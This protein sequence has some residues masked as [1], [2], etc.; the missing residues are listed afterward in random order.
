MEV[1]GTGLVLPALGNPNLPDLTSATLILTEPTL[2]DVLI[3]LEDLVLAAGLVLVALA[4]DDA[5]LVLLDLTSTL[6]LER[7]D[8]L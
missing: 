5:G 4:A 8:R 6:I 1:L 3:V 2:I 7:T